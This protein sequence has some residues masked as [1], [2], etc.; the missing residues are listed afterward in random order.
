MS[1]HQDIKEQVKSALRAKDALRLNVL[2]GLLTAFTNEAVAKKRKPA[3][4]L[5][6]E[7]ALVV[8]GRA[9]KQRKDSMAQFEKGGRK[10]LVEAEQAELAM[11]QTYLP[12]L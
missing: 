9:I 12:L 6:D 5:S 3:E 4:E 7:E 11:L 8:I 1:L 2:R 10:D